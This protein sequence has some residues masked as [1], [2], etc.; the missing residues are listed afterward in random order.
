MYSMIASIEHIEVETVIPLNKY[1]QRMY[2]SLLVKIEVLSSKRIHSDSE[3][4]YS[5]LYWHVCD[6]L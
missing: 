2:I 5:K 4:D 1:L 6:A 3:V